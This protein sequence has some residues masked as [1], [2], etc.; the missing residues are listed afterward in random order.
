MNTKQRKT[1]HNK[2]RKSEQD[3]NSTTLASTLK[4][5]LCGTLI[6]LS[7]ALVCISILT[8]YALTK[9]DPEGFLLKVASFLPYPCAILGGFV[10]RRS[11]VGK[12]SVICA[13]FSLMCVSLSLALYPFLTATLNNSL[14]ALSFFGLRILLI[15]CCIVGCV[16]GDRSLHQNRKPHRHRK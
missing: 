9:K 5:S 15:L 3:S 7:T 11:Y 6:S 10:S 4:S 12:C 8:A 14:S 2:K 1:P 16:M 13:V